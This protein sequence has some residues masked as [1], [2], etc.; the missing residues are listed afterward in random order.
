MVTPP[1][2]AAL[3]RMTTAG[4]ACVAAAPRTGFA[5]MMVCGSVVGLLDCQSSRSADPDDR[6][7]DPSS[8]STRVAGSKTAAVSIAAS[9]HRRRV[10]ARLFNVIAMARF[11]IESM[12]CFRPSRHTSSPNAG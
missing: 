10:N 8:A 7:T 1:G 4:L 3:P 9:D 5:R 2:F 12:V 11:S 6:Y